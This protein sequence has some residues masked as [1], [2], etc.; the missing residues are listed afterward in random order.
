MTLE[1]FIATR[2]ESADCSV[3]L[4]D[5]LAQGPGYIYADKFYIGFVTDTYP[6]KARAA[7]RYHLI[8]NNLEWI[9]DDLAD[10][11]AKLFDYACSEGFV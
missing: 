8:L 1:Q 2:R 11:E 4:D 9:S 7:G 10:L 6:A 5:E 3:D